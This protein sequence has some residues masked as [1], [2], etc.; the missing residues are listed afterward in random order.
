MGIGSGETAQVLGFGAV[1]AVYRGRCTASSVATNSYISLDAVLTLP[2]V[3]LPVSEVPACTAQQMTAEHGCNHGWTDAE[4]AAAP[5]ASWQALLRH[6]SQQAA[7]SPGLL[8]SQK[9]AGSD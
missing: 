1:L 7:L 5:Q 6:I 2:P 3:P 4:P 8:P 9:L